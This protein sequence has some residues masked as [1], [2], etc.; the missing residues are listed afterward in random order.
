MWTL[1]WSSLHAVE[2]NLCRQPLDRL[3]QSV[4]AVRT[5]VIDETLLAWTK[6]GTSQVRVR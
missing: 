2:V 1:L 6:A 5:V 4:I 3:L